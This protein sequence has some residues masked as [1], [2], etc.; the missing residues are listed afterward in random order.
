MRGFAAAVRG[1]SRRLTAATV[2]CLAGLALALGSVD[3]SSASPAVP[4]PIWTGAIELGLPAN[5]S[6]APIL[7][8]GELSSVSC[9]SI[10]NCVAVG[11]YNANDNPN[12][13]LA[14][15]VTQAGGVWGQPSELTPPADAETWSTTTISFSAVTCPSAGNC[16][17]VGEYPEVPRD[18][19]GEA[20]G[21]AMVA[22][23]S[24]GVWSQASQF[25]RLPADTSLTS[26]AC[27]SVGNC[28]AVGNFDVGENSNAN[29][30]VIASPS[31]LA[32]G[33][34]TWSS[35]CR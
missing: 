18:G 29:E 7:R 24:A 35:R 22:T 14:M 25:V 33:S 19:L 30:H 5:A 28:V 6:T 17:A 26:V 20:T 27:T 8:G 9:T 11:Q 4:A 31:R 34:A 10:G 15:V 16:V 21:Q 2:A 32:C 3:A 12:S 1:R 23:E 13:K